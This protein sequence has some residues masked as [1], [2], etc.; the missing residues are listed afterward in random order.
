MGIDDLGG[1]GKDILSLEYSFSTWDD[2][3][4][5]EKQLAMSRDSF[6]C[7]ILVEEGMNI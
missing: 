3:N 1:H 4:P 7:P 5:P 2:F 6:G